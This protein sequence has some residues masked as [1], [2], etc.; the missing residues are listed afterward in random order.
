VVDPSFLIM[1]TLMTTN[2][3]NAAAIML[4]VTIRIRRWRAANLGDRAGR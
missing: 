2:A 1:I 3:S 4:S